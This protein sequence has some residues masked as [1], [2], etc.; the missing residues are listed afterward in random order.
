MKK[1]LLAVLGLAALLVAAYVVLGPD[2]SDPSDSGDE[3]AMADA[4]PG[5]EPQASPVDLVDGGLPGDSTPGGLQGAE[6]AARTAVEVD[7]AV[8]RTFGDW[9]RD[10]ARI[11]RGRVTLPGGLPAD[12]TLQVLALK[13]SLRAYEIYGGDGAITGIASVPA[14]PTLFLQ[15]PTKPSERPAHLDSVPHL[16]GVAPVRA[17]GTFELRF[18]G[19]LACGFIAVDGRYLYSKE[20]TRVGFDED[21][22]VV[23]TPSV[24]A[25]VTGRVTLPPGLGDDPEVWEG[26]EVN[27]EYDPSR[28]SFFDMGNESFFSRSVGVRPDGWYELR[29]VD[30][31]PPYRLSFESDDLANR[32][33]GSL[34]AE[35]GRE[36]VVDVTLLE[37]GTLTGR[38][39]DTAGAP[40]EEA[41]LVASVESMFGFSIDRSATAET[42]AQG[43]FVLAHVPAGKVKVTASKDGYLQSPAQKV[44]LEDLGLV[45]GLEFEISTGNVVRGRVLFP[46]G[47]PVEGAEVEVDFDPAAL[48]GM[49]AFNAARGADGDDET[50]ADG[51]YAVTG[52]GKGPFVVAASVDDP[53]DPSVTWFAR[54]TGVS[55]AQDLEVDFVLEPMPVV[56]GV[57][58]DS[59]GRPVGS[60]SIQA[61]RDDIGFWMGIEA[62]NEEFEDEEGR[63]VMNGLYEGAWQIQATAEGY[64]DSEWVPLTTPRVDSS[65]IEV[66]LPAAATVRGIVSAPDGNPIPG[67]KVTP[68]LDMQETIAAA[69]GRLQVAEAFS[70]DAGHFE[71]RGLTPGSI[72]LVASHPDWT[73]SSPVGVDL[74]EG[75]LTEG[76]ELRLRI[77][78]TLTGE[79][80]DNEGEPAGGVMVFLQN[81]ANFMPEWTETEPDGTFRRE[82]MTPGTWNVTAMMGDGGGFDDLIS[83]EGEPDLSD[84]LSNMKFDV[85]EVE[86]DR[87]THVVLGAQPEDP[88]VL[89]G[90]V[91]HTGE[92]VP[93]ALVFVFPE[94]AEGFGAMKFLDTDESGAYETVLDHPGNYMVQVQS[95]GLAGTQQNSVEYPITVPDAEEHRFDIELPEG[96]I[97]GRVRGPDGDPLPDARV[98]LGTDGGIAYGTFMG[99][100]YV[101]TTTGADGSYEI[102]YV[103]PGSYSISAGGTLLG[104]AF[105]GS[106]ENGRMVKSGVRVAE[107]QWVQGVDFRLQRAG[108]ISGQVLDITGTPVSEAA[109][110]LR[111]EDGNLLERF[112]MI[113]SDSQGRFRCTGIAPGNYL[114]SARTKEMASLEGTVI[115]VRE[116]AVAETRVTVD[117]GTLMRITVI[118]RSGTV[119]KAR[120]SVVDPKGHEVNGMLAYSEIM[121]AAGGFYTTTEQRVGPLPPGRYVVT[122]IADDGRTT[123]KPVTLTGQ[124]ERK[125][126]IRLK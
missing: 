35:P 84:F 24:G 102:L 121:D 119:V 125:L 8:E 111:D 74:V 122:A 55:P 41:R 117:A 86:D 40:V 115:E 106:S 44:E 75:D 88:V 12:E 81:Q 98:T 100:Q 56:S 48:T 90:K 1:L 113:T 118:D 51:R 23:L 77:G 67:A 110:F 92:P 27:L 25:W 68:E 53:D 13:R 21:V 54:R 5:E 71:L 124:A 39:V 65:P 108:E 73:P 83:Q 61:R 116:D 96:R 66:V 17:D 2:S 76:V 22:P 34:E 70:D 59:A 32:L 58:I 49:A 45:E 126:K 3:V 114:V 78:G 10:A 93:D 80:Y 11:V 120:V 29:G 104:G 101:E 18:P 123:T 37:G 16:L 15:D 103:R 57:A 82:N 62:V 94:G 7:P 109:I 72:A 85:A 112:S 91:T 38:V 9:D 105:G 20:V 6:P 50:G 19:D 89:R 26:I 60:F 43:R 99:G 28:F 63:W 64:G 47:N 107:G 4:P 31:T 79:V 33:T 42:D 36:K 97:T 69:G 95:V 14:N 52:L 87:E 46:N 30:T